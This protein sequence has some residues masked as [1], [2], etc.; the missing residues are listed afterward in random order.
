MKLF[1]FL[2]FHKHLGENFYLDEDDD[3]VLWKCIF[4]INCNKP[5]C[6]LL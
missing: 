3:G 5:V 2:G 4:C 6:K 1:C